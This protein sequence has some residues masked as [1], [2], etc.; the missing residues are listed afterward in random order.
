MRLYTL[1]LTFCMTGLPAVADVLQCSGVDPAWSARIDGLDGSFELTRPVDMDV[2][3][4][5]R[6]V[7]RD[8]P[9]AY[10]L[11]GRSDTA[12]VIVSERACTLGAQG[13]THTADVLTQRADVPILLTGCCVVTAA[14]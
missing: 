7:N 4:S 3:Q 10:T 13:F 1:A 11:L 9:R 14:D 6:A 8:W 2:P 12:I 5:A